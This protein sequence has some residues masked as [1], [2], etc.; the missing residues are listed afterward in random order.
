MIACI[1]ENRNAHGVKPVDV[2]VRIEA[3]GGGDTRTL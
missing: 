1:D 2:A 3:S